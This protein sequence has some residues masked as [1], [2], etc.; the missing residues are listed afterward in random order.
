M[1][2]CRIVVVGRPGYQVDLGELDRLLP[3]AALLIRMLDTPIVDVSSTDIRRRVREGRT[4][5][6]LLPSPVEQYIHQHGLYRVSS[7]IA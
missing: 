3:G 6:Y 5:H 4:V 2:L 1:R 7:D